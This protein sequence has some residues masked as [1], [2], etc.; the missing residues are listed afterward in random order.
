M[1]HRIVCVALT[2]AFMTLLASAAE[3]KFVVHE[4]GVLLRSTTASESYFVPPDELVA[5]LP[6]FV[7]TFTSAPQGN[8]R[9]PAGVWFKP[10][11]HFYGRNDLEIKVW[12]CTAKGVPTVYWP[13]PAITRN[14]A[15]YDLKWTGKLCDKA[16]ENLPALHRNNWWNIARR[17]PGKYVSTDGGSERF[18][19]YEA[20]AKQEPTVTATVTAD[21]IKVSN[22]D[23]KESGPVVVIVNDGQTRR[24]A[25]IDKIN[26]RG[27]VTLKQDAVTAG[28]ESGEALLEACR[29]QWQA[30][31]MTQEE[32]AAIVEVWKTDLLK[33]QG[34]LMMSRMPEPLYRA[35]FPLTIVPVPDE[36]VRAGVVFDKLEGE[37][38]RLKWLP[39][40]EMNIE[41][42][43]AK[44]RDDEFNVREKAQ[45]DLARFGDLARDPLTK[46]ANSD[47]AEERSAA[48]KLLDRLKPQKPLETPQELNIDDSG[49]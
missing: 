41:K 19:F 34:F 32:A 42:L 38:Q 11:L 21:E 37:T 2:C 28:D 40:L 45:N 6:E 14:A 47:D 13:D 8:A 12:L 17:V 36:I 18:I 35:M 39:K 3:E 22:A 9:R 33:T 30:Y 27:G 16:P 31:G 20:T 10:V 23:E 25:K 4:W 46:A 29:A 5:Q 26:A 24:W 48:K 44:L 1:S 43:T 7:K 49:L 15:V